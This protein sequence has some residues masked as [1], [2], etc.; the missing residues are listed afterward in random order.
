MPRAPETT[1]GMDLPTL[2]SQTGCVAPETPQAPA[3]GTI[4][5]RVNSPLWSDG[6]VKQRWMAIPDDTQIVAQGDGSFAFPIGSVLVKSFAVDDTPVETRLLIRHQDGG[7]AGYSYEWLDDGSDAVLL[8]H[9]KTIELASGQTWV[10]PSRAQ[11]LECHTQVAGYTLGLELA[12]LNGEFVYPSTGETANQLVTLQHIGVLHDPQERLPERLPVLV[13]A[14][15]NSRSFEDRA[16]SYLHANCSG[17]HRPDGPTQ[18]LMDLRFFVGIESMQVCNV[19]PQL[20][21][22]GIEHAALIAPGAPERSVV[23]QR[24][25]RRTPQQMPP[26]GTLLVDMV[27]LEMMEQWILSED[28]GAGRAWRWRQLRCFGW[29]DSTGPGVDAELWSGMAV[30]AVAGAPAYVASLFVYQHA[31]CFSVSARMESAP[32]WSDVFTVNTVHVINP[33]IVG[34][35]WWYH[36]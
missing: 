13:A 6:A 22:L 28:G 23:Y 33:I 3:E 8:E 1:E 14:G 29:S 2:L 7:W 21:D 16:R 10:F 15:D 17:C 11:C 30:S 4:P 24:M 9:G 27:A 18:S 35:M 26:L 12:Q 34:Y 36:P 20:G 32:V 31:V 19:A 5:Y 25:N